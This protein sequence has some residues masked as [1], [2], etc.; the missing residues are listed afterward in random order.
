MAKQGGPF[1][2]NR[3]YGNISFYIR[4]GI[5]LVRTKSNLTAHRVKTD[6]A[7]KNSRKSAGNFGLANSIA[8]SVYK[9]IP[10][11]L[12]KKAQF[13]ALRN[14]AIELLHAGAS[15]TIAQKT[16]KTAAQ[17]LIVNLQQKTEEIEVL[18]AGTAIDA[19]NTA[20]RFFLIKRP[21]K[22]HHR[23]RLRR[24]PCR[25]ALTAAA[26]QHILSQV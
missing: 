18:P 23:K 24:S 17:N 7:F 2:F 16:M 14:L 26:Q 5:G 6:P 11:E 25:A 9:T 13:S 20:P 21:I 15:I 3:T 8:S 12:R 19:R 4:E 1:L 10:A 22:P